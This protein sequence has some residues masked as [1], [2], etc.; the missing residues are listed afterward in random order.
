MNERETEQRLR[1]WLD[2]Q[3]PPAVPDGLRR[4]VAA[5]PATVT[6]GWPDRLAAALGPRRAAVPRL[7]WVLVLVAGLLATLVGGMLVVGS[8]QARRLPAVMLPV[9]PSN[10]PPIA[11]AFACPPGS[12]P[13]EPGPVDQA[14]PS[15]AVVAPMA[16]DR[17]EGR[18]VLVASAVTG[19]EFDPETWTF[20]VCTNTWSRMRPDREPSVVVAEQSPMPEF[21]SIPYRLVYDADSDLTIAVDNHG[22]VWAYDLRANT[23]RQKGDAPVSLPQL[24]YDPATG[25]VVAEDFSSIGETGRSGLWTYDVGTDTWTPIP[26]RQDVY[27]DARAMTW[28]LLGYDA[29]VDRVL[30][31]DLVT[32]GTRLFDLRTGTSAWSF[33]ARP[34][35]NSGPA[36]PF[37]GE[38]AYD[39]TRART[40]VFADGLMIAYDAR[41]DRWATLDGLPAWRLP[42]APGPSE[43]P[44]GPTA[45]QGHSM[46]YDAANQRLVVYGGRYRASQPPANDPTGGTWVSADDVLAFDPA[47]GRW[48][49]LLARTTP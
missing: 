10:A 2:A 47:T 9:V 36:G 45:R 37:S 44:I 21:Q 24:V 40:V 25:L 34:F 11:P 38:M 17:R 39:D 35:V 41:A 49:E 7:A 1:D 14:R 5:V 16:F 19:A 6:V 30:W 20:D 43:L 48:T 33:A 4:A 22:A 8:Q 26:I 42:P 27:P 15:T 18:I 31:Y 13:D 29:S 23:W 32:A 3:V 46:V 28:G 12:T